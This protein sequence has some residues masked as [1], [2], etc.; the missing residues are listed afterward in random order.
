MWGD[1]LADIFAIVIVTLAIASPGLF[2]LRYAWRRGGN[3]RRFAIVVLTCAGLLILWLLFLPEDQI[4]RFIGAWG[5]LFMAVGII[6]IVG[7]S[8]RGFRERKRNRK[9]G[10][11]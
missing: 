11:S 7:S 2:L 6:T 9:D 1:M 5:I 8:V 3:H 4:S 10:G